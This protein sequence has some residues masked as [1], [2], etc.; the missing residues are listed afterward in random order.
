MKQPRYLLFA[1]LALTAKTVTGQD[2]V[3]PVKQVPPLTD[4]NKKVDTVKPTPKLPPPPVTKSEAAAPGVYYSGT[5]DGNALGKEWKLVNPDPARWT[6]QPKRKSIMIIAQKGGCLGK[7]SKNQLVLDKELPTE[8]FEVVVRASAQFQGDGTE[9]QMFLFNDESNFILADLWQGGGSTFTRFEKYF[10][11][12][13]NGE[14]RADVHGAHDV[15]LKMDRDSNEY[16]G[17]FATID[18]AKPVNVDQVQWVKLGTLPWIHF[19]PKLALCA[20]IGWGDPPQVS[21]EF[22]SVLIR[23]K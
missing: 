19:Q 15:Y 8:D 22:Y 4:P 23:K 9:I 20:C 16:S 17:Y 11:G 10:Q 2:G 1:L 6:M 21:A 18:P 7:D 12:Q 13:L 3:T 5:F 14:F